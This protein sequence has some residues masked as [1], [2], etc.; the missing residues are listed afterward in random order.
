MARKLERI[1]DGDSHLAPN[2]RTLKLAWTGLGGAGAAAIARGVG[3]S[4]L[5]DVDLSWNAFRTDESSAAVDA[6]AAAV[7]S[8]ASLAHVDVSFN[9]MS[10]ADLEGLGDALRE[11]DA[12]AAVHAGGN[13]AFRL[14]KPFLDAPHPADG[15]D[16]FD[17]YWRPRGTRHVPRRAAYAR[18]RECWLCARWRETKFSWT[19]GRSDIELDAAAAR[20]V[21]ASGRL[22]VELRCAYDGWARADA[23][24]DGGAFVLWRLVPPGRQQYAFSLSA[25]GGD[26][27]SFQNAAYDQPK[28]ALDF[29]APNV[30]GRRLLDEGDEPC[31]V[32][33]AKEIGRAHV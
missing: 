1:L 6:L 28:E 18:A 31:R 33:N 7:R 14:E 29:S 11:S 3:K 9:H 16:G 21:A 24:R 32:V 19:P 5:T 27:A 25:D 17:V 22:T 20:P 12:V 8:N 26:A 15:V 30:L 10:A 23:P 4:S 13:D 2:L